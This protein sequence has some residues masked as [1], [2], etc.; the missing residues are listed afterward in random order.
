[1]KIT[2]TMPEIAALIR[3]DLAQRLL[4]SRDE[5]DHSKVSFDVHDGERLEAVVTL[6]KVP[7]KEKS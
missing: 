3:R 1:M 5:I 6:N 2:Y 7:L 4:V